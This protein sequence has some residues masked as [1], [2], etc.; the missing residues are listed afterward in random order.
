MDEETK[1]K[2]QDHYQ[3]GQGSIQDLARV[4]RY[5]VEE[6]LEVLGQSDIT[7]IE[8]SGDLIDQREAGPETKLNPTKKFNVN[9]TVN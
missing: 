6:V 3:K 1:K 8:T 5:T 2:I 4:Y 9:F 7:T